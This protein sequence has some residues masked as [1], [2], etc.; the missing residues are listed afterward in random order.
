MC[1]SP[2]CWKITA[3][4][5]FYIKN[6]KKAFGIN[7][8]PLHKFGQF[9]PRIW[10]GTNTHYLRRNHEDCKNLDQFFYSLKQKIGNDEISNRKTQ[11]IEKNKILRKGS[12]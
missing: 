11:S 6:R 7:R 8:R 1:T 3:W 2:L 4:G 9:Q 12:I 5:P 10:S